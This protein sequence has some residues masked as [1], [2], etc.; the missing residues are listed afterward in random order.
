MDETQVAKLL[1]DALTARQTGVEGASATQAPESEAL[2]ELLALAGT[3]GSGLA[4]ASPTKAVVARTRAR[5]LNRIGASRGGTRPEAR[6]SRRPRYLRRYAFAL[7]SLLVVFA[8]LVSS[9]G[10][11]Y[12]A[13]GSLPGDTLYG[14]KLGYEATRLAL[15]FSP[16]ARGAYLRQ[17]ADQRVSE[18]QALVQEGRDDDLPSAAESYG[19]TLNQ[20]E[21]VAGEE[22]GSNLQQDRATLEHHLQVLQTLLASAPEPAQK[23]LENALT[24]SQHGLDVFDA[25][26]QGLSPSELAPGQLK[27]TPSPEDGSGNGNGNQGNGPPA[28]HTPGP[29]GG[30]PGQN[31]SQGG[32][33]GPPGDHTPGPPGG[34]PGQSNGGG[35]GSSGNPPG[36]NK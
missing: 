28:D 1:D 23:G 31:G 33:K 22:D 26:E 8:L 36:Q 3:L 9:T 34:P 20:L 11:A 30:P 12:A 17:L 35:S 27:K 4:P 21:Q 16:E 13:S 7:A 14:V 18:I 32:G 6:P 5:V 10:V 25:L 2:A 24:K 19:N 15:T 29:P